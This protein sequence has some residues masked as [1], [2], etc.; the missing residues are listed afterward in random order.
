MRWRIALLAVASLSCASRGAATAGPTIPVRSTAETPAA[1]AADADGRLD[2]ADGRPAEPDSDHDRIPDLRDLCPTE[3]ETYNHPDGTP[4]TEDGCPGT[5]SYQY[6][7]EA[8]ALLV[9]RPDGTL[10]PPSERRVVQL[11]QAARER[12]VA[13]H[14]LYTNVREPARLR[15]LVEIAGRAGLGREAVRTEHVASGDCHLGPS[16][17]ACRAP[18]PDQFGLAGAPPTVL[19]LRVQAE[20]CGRQS[21]P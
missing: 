9:S 13:N 11:A 10:A 8:S 5:R 14:H 20:P 6:C 18:L 4:A 15:A 21:A 17:S 16:S 1:S 19:L 2:Q 12:G 3:P 7:V